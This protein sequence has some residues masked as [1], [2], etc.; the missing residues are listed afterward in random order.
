MHHLT[1]IMIHAKSLGLIARAN[2]QLSRA[3]FQEKHMSALRRGFNKLRPVGEE[4]RYLFTHSSRSFV[5]T[6][7]ARRGDFGLQFS[8]FK[9][10]GSFVVVATIEAGDGVVTGIENDGWLSGN[11][12]QLCTATPKYCPTAVDLSGCHVIFLNLGERSAGGCAH[13]EGTCQ[14][15]NFHRMR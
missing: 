10:I 11:T 9:G 6:C 2:A 1:F 14:D 15:K 13:Q 8:I 3:V 12:F 4:I 5:S 7:H